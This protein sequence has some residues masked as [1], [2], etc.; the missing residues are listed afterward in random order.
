MK[1]LGIPKIIH[2]TWKDHDL[3]QS[4]N[5]WRQSWLSRHPDWEYRF[6][7]DED[8]VAFVEK[9]FPEWFDIYNQYSK[10][11][12][13]ADLFRYLIIYHNGGLYADMD[14]ECFKPVDKLF[15]QKACVFSIEA[16]VTA[17]L[18]RELNYPDSYQVANCVFA[19]CPNDPL[20][21]HILNRVKSLS[22]LAIQ[23]DSDVEDSTGPRML[24][25]LFQKMSKELQ[26]QVTILPQINLMSPGFYP[27]IYPINWNMYARH[28]CFGSWKK[29]QQPQS[30]KRR[31]V[32]RNRWPMLW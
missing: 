1:A 18:Q 12:Q 19:A 23:N 14:M 7:T 29:N 11:V 10:P 2:Q 32:E 30:I 17:K 6:Y 15:E 24:T 27:N 25:R 26:S 9:E 21:W 8:C 31:L 4:F 13:R 28:H 22:S 16:H 5:T 20:L 3:P